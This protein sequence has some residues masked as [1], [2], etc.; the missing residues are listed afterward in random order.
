MPGEC[1]MPDDGDPICNENGDLVRKEIEGGIEEEE[2]VEV[3]NEKETL[4]D[5]FAKIWNKTP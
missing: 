5:K 4:G 2:F 1:M 3:E